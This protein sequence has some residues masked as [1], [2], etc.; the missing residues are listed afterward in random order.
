MSG[1]APANAIC[2]ESEVIRG[3][4]S[5][6]VRTYARHD[7]ELPSNLICEVFVMFTI[8]TMVSMNR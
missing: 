8:D 7:P 4:V 2:G 1:Q 6:R 5:S 3:T